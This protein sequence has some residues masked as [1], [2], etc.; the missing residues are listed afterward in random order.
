MS[1]S[2]SRSLDPESAELEAL[3]ARFTQFASR[4]GRDRGLAPS[5][6][7]ELV[8]ELRVRLWQARNGHFNNVSAGYV[9]RTAI[10]AALDVIRRRRTDRN[11]ALP[12]EESA[13]HPIATNARPD[14]L[15]ERQDLAARVARAVDG[16]AA[17]RR[18]A[19]RMYLQG[20]PREE[21]AALLR[22]SE[23]KTRNLLYRGL[24]DLRA[25]LRAEGIGPGEAA[26]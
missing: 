11:V 23:A 18:A 19:V 13:P 2:S 9:R 7:D 20:Y 5:E 15:F 8:Q 3:V 16:L 21:I 24:A 17:P 14:E 22:W 10:S 26:T 6:L 1:P 12:A 4:I 25:V